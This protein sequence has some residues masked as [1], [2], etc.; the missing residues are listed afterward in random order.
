MMCS[1]SCC[2]L[3]DGNMKFGC[4]YGFRGFV[5]MVFAGLHSYGL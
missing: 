2:S 1:C 4:V 3:S 5:E